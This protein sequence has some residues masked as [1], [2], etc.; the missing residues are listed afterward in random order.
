[1]PNYH[2]GKG[3][4]AVSLRLL[5]GTALQYL[6]Q[7]VETN[8]GQ[9]P[10]KPISVE[11]RCPHGNYKLKGQSQNWWRFASLVYDFMAIWLINV[12]AW[13]GTSLEEMRAFVLQVRNFSLSMFATLLKFS[14]P[15]EFLCHVEIKNLN[16]NWLDTLSSTFKEIKWLLFLLYDNI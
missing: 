4:N 8:T 5:S 6:H 14:T 2:L 1:M 10:T 7:D 9:F 15:T 11:H 13:T 16:S 12:W 3:L